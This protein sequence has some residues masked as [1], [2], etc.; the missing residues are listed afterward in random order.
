MLQT[1]HLSSSVRIREDNSSVYSCSLQRTFTETKDEEWEN[2]STMLKSWNTNTEPSHNLSTASSMDPPTSTYIPERTKEKPIAASYPLSQPQIPSEPVS[3]SNATNLSYSSE[4]KTNQA[5]KILEK[6]RFVPNRGQQAEPKPRESVSRVSLARSFMS[7]LFSRDNDTRP[8]TPTQAPKPTVHTV[9]TCSN[10]G[11]ESSSTLANAE[12]DSADDNSTIKGQEIAQQPS[13]PSQPSLINE[14]SES[15]ATPPML[16]EPLLSEENAALDSDM[17]HEAPQV[18]EMALPSRTELCAANVTIQV[19]DADNSVLVHEDNEG[20]QP[21]QEINARVVEHTISPTATSFSEQTRSSYTTSSPPSPLSPRIPQMSQIPDNN[22]KIHCMMNTNS[23]ELGRIPRGTT[24]L[25]ASNNRIP[26]KQLSP[27]FSA[28]FETLMVLDLSFNQIFILPKEVGLLINLKELYLQGNMLHDLP[29]TLAKCL[30][31]EVLDLQGNIFEELPASTQKL[32]Q[33]RHL[34]IRNNRIRHIPPFLCC[35]SGTLTSFLYEGNPLESWYHELASPPPITASSNTNI[36]QEDN[37][38]TKSLRKLNSAPSLWRRQSQASNMSM[39]DDYENNQRT[40]MPVIG[41]T[42]A[43][44]TVPDQP[45]L[46]SSRAS[47]WSTYPRRLH[48]PPPKAYR[49][50]MY[51]NADDQ[52][53]YNLQD[54][55][56]SRVTLDQGSHLQRDKVRSPSPVVSLLKGVK[57]AMNLRRSSV[58][59]TSSVQPLGSPELSPPHM[60]SPEQIDHRGSPSRP[61]S[62]FSK[63]NFRLSLISSVSQPTADM[64][65]Y[66]PEHPQRA[67]AGGRLMRKS[68]RVERALDVPPPNFGQTMRDSGFARSWSVAGDTSLEPLEDEKVLLDANN[69]DA[70][71]D[72]R[73]DWLTPSLAMDSLQTH[74]QVRAMDSNPESRCTS[75]L[76][77]RTTA[78]LECED[79]ANL[80]SLPSSRSSSLSSSPSHST[81]NTPTRGFDHKMSPTNLPPDAH[82][83]DSALSRLLGGLRDLYDLDSETSE[84]EQVMAWRRVYNTAESERRLIY[85]NEAGERGEN[86]EPLRTPTPKHVRRRRFILREILT[87]ER[88]YVQGLQEFMDIYVEPSAQVLSPQERKQVFSNFESILAFH[89]DHFLPAL[90]EEVSRLTNDKEVNDMDDGIQDDPVRVGGVFVKLADFL[91]MYSFYINNCD[92]ALGMLEGWRRSRKPVKQLMEAA[93][94]HSRHAQI[95]FQGYLL[96]PVQRIPR[97]RL[98]LKDLLRNTYESHGDYADLRRASEAMEARAEEVNARKREHENHERIVQIQAMLRSRSR[99]VLVQHDRRL[100]REGFLRISHVARRV[101]YTESPIAGAQRLSVTYVRREFYFFLFNDIFVWCKASSGHYQLL[102]QRSAGGANA[103]IL[104][105]VP[106]LAQGQMQLQ[107]TLKLDSRLEP[108]SVVQVFEEKML[109]VVDS[110]GI[111]YLASVLSNGDADLDIWAKAINTRW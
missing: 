31:L 14:P 22:T 15:V 28:L 73:K 2:I 19:S 85:G 109:R 36:S 100:I 71:I 6:K 26:G 92:S 75:A 29:D 42:E 111:Y 54:R 86:I 91:R 82:P 95:N 110:T 79:P 5:P 108:A 69:L 107:M 94:T 13:P 18:P 65:R 33:L 63:S 17:N 89:R 74:R 46:D 96:L 38:R 104:P 44:V 37:A 77:I 55:R 84:Y 103:S 49:N 30:E 58:I 9:T 102:R 10:A 97:Y 52:S 106:T 12:D 48:S 87:T 70:V 72:E 78:S 24:H 90:E 88:S 83:G 11:R 80:M 68:S 101:P 39:K 3:Q 93:R 47:M 45:S 59:S 105:L 66:V 21:Q 34:D 43:Q 81:L 61:T 1:E 62:F 99:T 25:L 35:L 32:I 8:H 20:V 98:L 40:S 23:S 53:V 41:F 50:S 51:S 64:G 67:S 27:V 57:D 76:T 60:I 7:R 4:M 56:S 16:Q